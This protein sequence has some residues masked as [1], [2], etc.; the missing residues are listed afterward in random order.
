MD[1]DVSICQLDRLDTNVA[2]EQA[3]ESIQY[4]KVKLPRK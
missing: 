1:D 3:S 2:P 4:T